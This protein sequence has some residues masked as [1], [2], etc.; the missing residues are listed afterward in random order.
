MHSFDTPYQKVNNFPW[1]IMSM[2]NSYCSTPIEK[3]TLVEKSRWC[4]LQS[5]IL[6]LVVH[7]VV[8]LQ[9]FRL[10]IEADDD[11][12]PILLQLQLLL[13]FVVV[14]VVVVVVSE[15]ALRTMI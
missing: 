8:S 15:S 12:A 11:V 4:R 10:P 7:F 14:V 3:Y 13:H 1:L 9:W 6:M 2:W 5:L